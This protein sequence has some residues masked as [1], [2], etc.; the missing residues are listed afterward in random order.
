MLVL[1]DF[2]NHLTMMAPFTGDANRDGSIKVRCCG[3]RQQSFEREFGRLA[4]PAV[5]LRSISWCIVSSFCLQSQ[6]SLAPMFNRQSVETVESTVL[7]T[8]LP[9]VRLSRLFLLPPFEDFG[10]FFLLHWA[11]F[12]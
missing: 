6:E 3:N 9:T 4:L 5:V 2:R 1:N 7:S 8:V 12:V 10:G 11:Q